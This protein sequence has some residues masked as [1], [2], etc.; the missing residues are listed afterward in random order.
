MR[1]EKR[2]NEKRNV[3]RRREFQEK[4]KWYFSSI[5]VEIA[6]KLTIRFGWKKN[7]ALSQ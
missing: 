3:E 4:R 7:Y 1:R 6:A 5:V 2:R